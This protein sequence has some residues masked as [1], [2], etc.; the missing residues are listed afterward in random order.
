[1]DN[2]RNNP[3]VPERDDNLSRSSSGSPTEPYKGREPSKP[4]GGFSF[5]W[6][7]IST[8][9][10]VG[11]LAVSWIGW[12][13]YQQFIE[14]QQRFEVLDSRLNNTDESVNQSGAAMQVNIGKHSEQLKKHW[15]EIRKLW[16]VANDKNKRKITKNTKDISFLASKRSELESSLAKLSTQ[17]DKDRAVAEGVG[18]NFFGLSADLDKLSKS[19]DD[20]FLSVESLKAS[21]KQQDK[22]IQSNNEAVKSIDAFRRQI[23]QKIL[24][25]EKKIEKQ[26]KQAQTMDQQSDSST[27]SPE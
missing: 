14:L 7:L 27:L 4:Q 18:E 10:L 2:Q 25:L 22:K 23:N 8:V 19:L 17:V 24:N 9:A 11:M 6:K 20:Y 12:Q 5:P 15:S 16:G 1:M 3:I 13:Q 21:L 26:A